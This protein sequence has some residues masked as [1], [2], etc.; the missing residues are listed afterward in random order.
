MLRNLCFVCLLLLELLFAT[1]NSYAFRMCHRIP[2]LAH[3]HTRTY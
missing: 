1:G 3:E 2:A